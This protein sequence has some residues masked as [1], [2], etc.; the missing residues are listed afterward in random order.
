MK[1]GRRERNA[2]S[3]AAAARWI[4][5]HDGNIRVTQLLSH[6]GITKR[7]LDRQFMNHTGLTPK[8]F[9][10]VVRFQT[11]MKRLLA[12][13]SVDWQELV[14]LYGYYDQSHLID[15][16]RYATTFPPEMLLRQKGRTVIKYKTGIF[17]TRPLDA[18]PA[19]Y[20]EIMEETF[21]SELGRRSGEPG[22]D[23]GLSYRS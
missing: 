21:Q 19:T 23:S 5:E 20:R 17:L 16:F 4:A 11:V 18:Q 13:D 8:E 3:S 1:A 15:E 9:A 14:N 2:D 22:L 10:R 7:T 6:L 12:A